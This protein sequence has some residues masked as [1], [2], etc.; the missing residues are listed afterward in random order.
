MFVGMESD[1]DSPP[2]GHPPINSGLNIT[3]H[4]IIDSHYARS[5][6]DQYPYD[7][8]RSHCISNEDRCHDEGC[9]RKLLKR[10]TH[11]KQ[12]CLEAQNES[13][14]LEEELEAANEVVATQMGKRMR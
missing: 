2:R 5:N 3:G 1:N 14:R 8:P 11:F 7:C 6:E 13:D 9:R 10:L 4:I 12:Q